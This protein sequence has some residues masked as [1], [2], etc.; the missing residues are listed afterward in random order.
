MEFKTVFR[1][2]RRVDHLTLVPPP[3]LVHK[4]APIDAR[5]LRTHDTDLPRLLVSVPKIFGP[6]PDRNRF[7]RV[8][9]HAFFLALQQQTLSPSWVVWVRPLR[10]TK[11][12][13]PS[14]NQMTQHLVSLIKGLS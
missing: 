8:A 9:R 13:T 10:H 7:K 3:P 1:T 4:D 12:T 2:V 5:A 11:S 6:A 14:M